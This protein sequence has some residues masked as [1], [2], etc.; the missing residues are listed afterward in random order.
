MKKITDEDELFRLK[1]RGLDINNQLI[2]PKALIGLTVDA[3][4]DSGR[5]YPAVINRL[6]MKEGKEMDEHRLGYPP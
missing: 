4:D 6:L 1:L 2:D 5:W 3:M